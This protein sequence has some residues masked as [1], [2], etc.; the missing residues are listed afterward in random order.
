MS[1][2]GGVQ[3]ACA[4]PAVARHSTGTSSST[5]D[6]ISSRCS[7]YKQLGRLPAIAAPRFPAC[8][9]W[10]FES[11]QAQVIIKCLKLSLSKICFQATTT[12]TSQQHNKI[13][14][15][16]T[17]SEI[18]EQ[19]QRNQMSRLDLYLVAIVQSYTCVELIL[20]NDNRS[21][22]EHPSRGRGVG[23]GYRRS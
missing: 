14:E 9:A 13:S 23:H 5:G 20:S 15:I 6:S 12:I 21:C 3:G 16:S 11:S 10:R 2:H 18:V 8:T 22:G 19:R 4:T 7:D 1:L 17:I